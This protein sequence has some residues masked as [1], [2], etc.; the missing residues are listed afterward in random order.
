MGQKHSSHAMRQN[1]LRGAKA[2]WCPSCKRKGALQ[3]SFWGQCRW[4][5]VYFRGSREEHQRLYKE[6]KGE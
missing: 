5:K 2:R 4:C 1:A 6:W 3:A